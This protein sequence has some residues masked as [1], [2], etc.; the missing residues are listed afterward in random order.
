[1]PQAVGAFL[2]LHRCPPPC[3]D[4]PRHGQDHMV[5]LV[6]K[7]ATRV[8]LDLRFVPVLGS[9]RKGHDCRQWARSTGRQAPP[10]PCTSMSP[11][12]RRLLRPLR[13]LAATPALT[14]HG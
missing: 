14:A 2:D 13:W 11:K 6:S 9:D 12:K 3:P 10:W 8:L 4:D 7:R 5:P 1:M